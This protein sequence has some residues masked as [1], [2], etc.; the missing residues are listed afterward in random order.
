[1]TEGALRWH[2]GSPQLMIEQLEA[3]SLASKLPNVELGVIPYTTPVSIFP[4]HGFHLY[5]S[6]AAI[7]GTETGTAT[8]IDTDDIARYEAM[9]AELERVAVTGEAARE[10]LS[11]VSD[12]YRRL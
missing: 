10:V 5:D 2:A 9:F 11:R 12:D 3:I 4:R 6:D 8:I 1:M 7:V